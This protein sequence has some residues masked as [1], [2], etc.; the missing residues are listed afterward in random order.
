MTGPKDKRISCEYL[1]STEAGQ[2]ALD[3]R[4]GCAFR[5]TC[6]RYGRVL[7]VGEVHTLAQEHRINRARLKASNNP[8]ER[9]VYARTQPVFEAAEKELRDRY[10]RKDVP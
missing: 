4:V 5:D 3:E 8:L 9:K 1:F 10:Q 6:Q 7:T 2:V